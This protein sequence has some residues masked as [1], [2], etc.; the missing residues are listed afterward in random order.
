METI[1]VVLADDHPLMRRGICSML[2]R[3]EDIEVVGEARN[4]YEAL[5]MV[6]ELD[7]DVLLLDMEMPGLPGMEVAKELEAAGSGVPILALSAHEDKQY[8]LGILATGAAGYLTKEELPETIVRAV[9]GVAKGE[10]GW[11][12]RK[13]AEYLRRWQNQQH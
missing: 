3:T 7:P 11:V 13:I 4:G 10:N 8:I 6:H 1:R 9:R 5:S 12:S 2:N